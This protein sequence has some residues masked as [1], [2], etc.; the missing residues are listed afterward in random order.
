MPA[1]TSSA[2]TEARVAASVP[3]RRR[4][5]SPRALAAIKAALFTLSLL[6]LAR[7][8]AAGALG[9]FGGLGANP[10]ELVTRSTG[11]WTLVFLC[12]GLAVTPLRRITGLQWLVRLRRMI[13]LFAFF[14]AALHFTTYLWFD[15]WFDWA[16]I[17]KDIV[18]RPFITMGVAAFVLLVPLAA[19]STDAMVRLLGRRWSML[20]RLVYVAAAAGV[21]HFW[22]HKAGKNDYA[23]VGWYAAAL[24][25]LLGWRLAERLRARR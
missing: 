2:S 10:V 21:L 18:K 24:V 13:G 3:A 1:W 19:T 14:Y 20:H 5:P 8:V 15:Q 12:I 17:W 9:W 11:T 16:A 7:L 23:E 22:W 25:L 6:P 4:P